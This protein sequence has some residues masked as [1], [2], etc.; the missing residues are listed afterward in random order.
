VRNAMAEDHSW[1]K[2]AEEYIKLYEEVAR[3]RS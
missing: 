2:P 3:R 1:V